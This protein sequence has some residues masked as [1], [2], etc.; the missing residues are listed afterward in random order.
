MKY[1][2]AHYYN[3]IQLPTLLRKKKC[4]TFET[5]VN[6]REKGFSDDVILNYLNN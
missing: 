4:Y 3:Y 2:N 5:Y 1:L 6:S